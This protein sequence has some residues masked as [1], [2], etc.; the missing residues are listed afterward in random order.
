MVG[1]PIAASGD[2]LGRTTGNSALGLAMRGARQRMRFDF[3]KSEISPSER[4]RHP[5]GQPTS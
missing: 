2:R 1:P 5:V 3:E 4:A